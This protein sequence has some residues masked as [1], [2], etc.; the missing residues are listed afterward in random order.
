MSHFRVLIA[1]KDKDYQPVFERNYTDDD[2]EWTGE[3]FGYDYLAPESE[4]MKVK[5]ALR[6][7]VFT[8]EG[9]YGDFW[10]FAEIIQEDESLY[11]SSCVGDP[12]ECSREKA[13]AMLNP[14]YYCTVFNGHL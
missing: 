13:M 12:T 11:K 10:L 9:V 7:G 3:P 5:D 2:P 6:K 8:M 14:E 1:H 4:T